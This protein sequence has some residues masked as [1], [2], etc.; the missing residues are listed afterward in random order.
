MKTFFVNICH[1]FLLNM[2]IYILYNF[3]KFVNKYLPDIV[4]F[5]P[6]YVSY[7]NPC[8]NTIFSVLHIYAKSHTDVFLI[9]IRIRIVWVRL[10]RI[11]RFNA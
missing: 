1:W 4:I 6:C 3:F 10:T 11:N 9:S 8:V 5:V 2:L 7:W